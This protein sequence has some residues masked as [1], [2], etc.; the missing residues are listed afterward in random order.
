MWGNGHCACMAIRK[1]TWV[2]ILESSLF[3]RWKADEGRRADGTCSGPCM[4]GAN[5]HVTSFLKRKK[6]YNEGDCLWTNSPVLLH[7]YCQCTAHNHNIILYSRIEL[8]QVE[9]INSNLP[10]LMCYSKY[11][12]FYLDQT[13][14]VALGCW[15]EWPFN[16]RDS[17]TCLP[18]TH[19]R[20]SHKCEVW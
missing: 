5:P 15:Q 6:I 8:L 9:K 2:P 10:L 11:S 1:L 3:L 13:S 4:S 12:W 16:T 18:V 17:Q 19:G 20:H 14:I 7:E